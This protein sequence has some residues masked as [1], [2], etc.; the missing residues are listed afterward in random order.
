[1]LPAPFH[2]GAMRVGSSSSTAAA[3]RGRRVPSR[4]L[5][6]A[7]PARSAKAPA[8]GNA[9][10]RGKM[11]LA[12]SAAMRPTLEAP[13]G[14]RTGG[15]RGFRWRRGSSWRRPTPAGAPFPSAP[16]TVSSDEEVLVLEPPRE[17]AAA[18]SSDA[19]STR[20]EAKRQ[21]PSGTRSSS[22]TAIRLRRT[23]PS[24][25]L[26]GAGRARE[27]ER[28][29]GRPAHQ[30]IDV[31]RGGV[32]RIRGEELPASPT[33]ARPSLRDSGGLGSDVALFEDLRGPLVLEGAQRVGGLPG[34]R[35]RPRP[36]GAGSRKRS[37]CACR[38]LARRG[39]QGPLARAGCELRLAPLRRRRRPHRPPLPA[40]L[41]S[42][43]TTDRR[44]SRSSVVGPLGRVRA[45]AQRPAREAAARRPRRAEAAPM[46]E[47]RSDTSEAGP[48]AASRPRLP[49]DSRMVSTL[50]AIG[51]PSP[52]ASDLR[53]AVEPALVHARAGFGGFVPGAAD[54]EECSLQKGNVRHWRGRTGYTGAAFREEM[55]SPLGFSI[56]ER[57]PST[58]R[59]YRNRERRRQ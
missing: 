44:S 15:R 28:H 19:A 58:R 3:R 49:A 34:G 23:V 14:P 43:T 38:V 45:G 31:H 17:C 5:A 40:R 39:A 20:A 36:A 12:Q 54:C 18:L 6:P 57:R 53:G 27:R 11:S 41:D 13:I 4:R 30:G 10:T 16:K 35:P 25:A 9:A 1:M 7:A 55:Q 37:P 59:R 46:A 51:L 50:R 48:D 24:P 33:H 22:S 26:A 47:G 2:T 21:S 29:T 42:L 52:D 56:R 32:R 8:S